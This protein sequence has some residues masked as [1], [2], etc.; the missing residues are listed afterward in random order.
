M[1]ASLTIKETMLVPM[2]YQPELSITTNQENEIDESCPSW[3]TP[4]VRYLSSRE[5]L[6]NKAEADKI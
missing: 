3:I 1:A 2:Y 6:D 4:I 5:L